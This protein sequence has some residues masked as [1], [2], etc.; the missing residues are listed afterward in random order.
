[1]FDTTGEL[2]SQ[3]EFGATSSLSLTD[4]HYLGDQ[5]NAPHRNA[6]ADELAAM[7]NTAGG[8]LVL[9]TDSRSNSVTGIHEDKLDAVEA[10]VRGICNALINPPLFCRIRKIPVITESGAER[11]IVRIDVPGSLFV[12]QSPGGYFRRIGSSAR[13]M[14]PD[15]LARLFQ[16]RSQTR[17][18]RFDELPVTAA[19][20]ICLEKPLWEKFRTN[21]SPESDDEFL[22]RL[23]LLAKDD[24]GKICPSVSGILMA[25]RQPHAFLPSAFIQAVAYL[26]TQMNAAY[27]MDARDITGPLDLQIKEACRFVEKNMRVYTVKDPARRD[28]PQYAMRAVLEALVNAAAHMDYSL[29]G[30][31]I[32]LH[33]F[34]DRLEICSPGALP[35][36]MTTDSLPLRQA[37]RNELL[38]SLLARCP[39]P[40]GYF[41]GERR[42]LMD[43]RGEGVPVILTESERLSGRRPEYRLTAAPGLLLIIFAAQPPGEEA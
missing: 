37:A 23:R 11:T 5:I 41:P 1:M 8:V 31:G 18:I 33:M 14:P 6:M 34:A 22:L 42:F 13:Q 29:H 25:C 9:G 3:I 21:L 35:G 32:R 30:S 27:Q 15:V 28:I 43:K 24:D 36:T 10:W 12:H 40:S 2:L 39:V 38:T 26:G 4:L 19:P 7:A 20:R 17:L 16:R